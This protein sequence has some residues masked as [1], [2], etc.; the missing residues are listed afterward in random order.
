MPQV[1]LDGH[2]TD[3]HNNFLPGTAAA[4]LTNFTIT[5]KAVLRKDDLV[6]TH[7]LSTDPKVTHVLPSISSG[8]N[9]FTVAGKPIVR[10]GDDVSCGGKMALGISSFTVG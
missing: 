7:V 3:V 10:I 6:S 4:S 1:S 2:I 9:N 8:A 5:G